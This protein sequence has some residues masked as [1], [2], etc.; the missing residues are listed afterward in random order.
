MK[1]QIR[2]TTNTINEIFVQPDTAGISY[3]ETAQKC[4][5]S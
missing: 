3:S 5:S 4:L 1:A 2:M